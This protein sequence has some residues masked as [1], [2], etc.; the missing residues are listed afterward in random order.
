MSPLRRWLLLFPGGA[1]LSLALW[2]AEFALRGWEGREWI[3]A[4]HLAIPVSLVLFVASAV[5]VARGS[6]GRRTLLGASLAIFAAA[7]YHLM[8]EALLDQPWGFFGE[9][10]PLT[11]FLP[12]A[13]VIALPALLATLLAALRLWPGPGRVVASWALWVGPSWLLSADQVQRGTP[14]VP[15]Y[16]ALA[17]LFLP[18]PLRA[19]PAAAKPSGA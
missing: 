12:I 5:A 17:L 7:G 16:L 8:R 2:R 14:I 4:F 15:Y 19:A 9:P 13:F 6:A 1:F 10:L 18:R 3:S 11:F